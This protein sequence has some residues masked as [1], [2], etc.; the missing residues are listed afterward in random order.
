MINPT[1]T[2][3]EN[4]SDRIKDEIVLLFNTEWGNTSLQYTR[5]LL[6]DT[7]LKHPSDILLVMIN[8]VDGELIGTIGLD[9][10]YF[11]P[12]AGH[13]FVKPEYR[14]MGY[15]DMLIT[16]ME[17]QTDKKIYACCKPEKVKGNERRGW[18]KMLS[19]GFTGLFDL[20]PMSK[21]GTKK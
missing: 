12:V 20:V 3:L 16:A 6:E 17:Q 13:L 4:V 11:F 18:S 2:R 7:W 5:K 15:A 10:K 1:I 21:K 19:F 14:N 8:S 9:H